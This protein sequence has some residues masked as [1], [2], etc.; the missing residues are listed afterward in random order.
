MGRLRWM[1]ATLLLCAGC[2][3]VPEGLTPVQGFDPELER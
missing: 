3:G 1:M 2:T